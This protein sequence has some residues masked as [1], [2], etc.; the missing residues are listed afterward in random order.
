MAI[1]CF[2]IVS[3][4][5]AIYAGTRL[6]H[7]KKLSIATFLLSFLLPLPIII[8]WLAFKFCKDSGSSAAVRNENTDLEDTKEIFDVFEGPFRKQQTADLEASSRLP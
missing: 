4:P 8:Y 7:M 5:V 1:A 6:L 3:Y 2:W